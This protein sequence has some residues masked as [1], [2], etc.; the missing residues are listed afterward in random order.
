MTPSPSSTPCP[1]SPT[2]TAPSSCSSCATTSPCGLHPTA[3]RATLPRLLPVRPMP[4]RLMLTRPLRR[5]LRPSPKRPL[6]PHPRPS[7][8]RGTSPPPLSVFP[9]RYRDVSLGN[10]QLVVLSFEKQIFILSQLV[11][12]T[13]NTSLAIMLFSPPGFS[14][15]WKRGFC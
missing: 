13:E 2:A 9:A 10:P 6:P 8:K 5:R 12:L 14:K 15:F 4:P 3:L 7:P 11:Y 1:R